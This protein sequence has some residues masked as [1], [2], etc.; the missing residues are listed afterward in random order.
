[1]GSEAVTHQ[2]QQG[3]A[4]SGGEDGE[5]SKVRTMELPAQVKIQEMREIKSALSWD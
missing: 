3:L 4:E 2:N 1:M 5:I